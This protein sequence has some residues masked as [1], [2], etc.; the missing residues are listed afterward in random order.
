MSISVTPDDL[1]PVVVRAV[2]TATGVRMELFAPTDVARDALR[3]ILPELRR[4]LAGGALSASLDLSSRSQP[5][6]A[7]SSGR[8]DRHAADSFGQGGTSF[9]DSP[10]GGAGQPRQTPLA[11]AWL[12][13]VAN[14]AASPTGSST[15]VGINGVDSSRPGI[16][17][18][19]GRVDVLA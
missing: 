13:P 15:E 8:Q 11:D 6:D 2:I 19:G 1:G 4:D 14:G 3:L 10:R 17:I 18:S 5:G 9:G 16:D 7:G 12:R